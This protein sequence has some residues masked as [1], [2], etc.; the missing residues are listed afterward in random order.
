MQIWHAIKTARQSILRKVKNY[1]VIQLSLCSAELFLRVL[2][3]EG[4]TQTHQIRYRSKASENVERM[5]IG[6]KA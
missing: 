3:R 4:L 2:I 6:G 5:Y 1:T